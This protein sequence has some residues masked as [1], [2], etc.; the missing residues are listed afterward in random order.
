M[1]RASLN[2]WL[3]RDDGE[4]KYMGLVGWG[5]A[6]YVY[7]DK[8]FAGKPMP[9]DWDRPRLEVL[10]KTKKLGDCVGWILQSA[11]VSERARQ[12]FESLVGDDVQFVR[13]HDLRG[14]PY[15]A[16]NVLRIE[17]D[18]LDRDR[19]ECMESPNDDVHYCSRYVFKD[20]L[21][22]PLPPIFKVHPNSSIF[23]TRVFAEAIVDNKLTGFCLQDPS[24][25]AIAVMAK[26]M[27]LN[28]YPGLP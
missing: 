5:G 2:I 4:N 15:F 22:T 26:G 19:S 24:K 1:N 16:M 27:P 14:K 3:L 20:D 8:N 9:E 25:N 28:A 18:F 13:F 7:L 10:G 23:V 21:P 12:V 11:V 17:N 6:D